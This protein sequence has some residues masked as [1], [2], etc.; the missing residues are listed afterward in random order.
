[1]SSPVVSGKREFVDSPT[2][3]VSAPGTFAGRQVK[4][5]A[6]EGLKGGGSGCW[7]ISGCAFSALG[8]LIGM[9]AFAIA[10][11]VACGAFPGSAALSVGARVGCFFGIN[12]AGFLVAAPLSIGGGLCCGAAGDS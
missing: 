2:A 4:P 6:A 9:T 8:A 3:T 7:A 11:S 1:M 5:V 10:V 12:L